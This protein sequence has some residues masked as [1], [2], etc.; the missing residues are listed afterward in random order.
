MTTRQIGGVAAILFSMDQQHKRHAKDWTGLVFSRLTV[1]GPATNN[2]YGRMRW[3]CKC[4]CGREVVAVGKDLKRGNTK[5]CG[6]FRKDVAGDHCRADLS[7]KKIGKW[8]VLERAENDHRGVRWKCISDS[9]VVRV[10][11]SE[12]LQLQADPIRKM[13]LAL[14]ARTC[15][16]F[17]SSSVKKT[18]STM[19]LVGCS[20]DELSKHLSS[21]F[22]DGMTRENHGEWHIDHIKPISSFDLTDPEQVKR[23]FH[24]SNLQPLWAADNIAK[25]NRLDWQREKASSRQTVSA[26]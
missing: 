6:C 23:C 26:F 17:K 10:R 13:I 2:K 25:S 5:S 18:R 24:Y 1:T 8:T 3:V 7:G 22:L 19:E 16:A 4:V 11:R 20:G 15:S 12:V 9:G 14:R 21:M